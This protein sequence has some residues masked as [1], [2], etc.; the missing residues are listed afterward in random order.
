[1]T[2]YEAKLVREDELRRREAVA[3]ETREALVAAKE[4]FDEAERLRRRKR[5]ELE[6]AGALDKA[7][8]RRAFELAALDSEVAQEQVHWERSRNKRRFS[9][10]L[11]AT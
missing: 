2:L 6:L 9:F 10:T 4:R 7:E 1:M 5:Q 8:G 11:Y 3:S